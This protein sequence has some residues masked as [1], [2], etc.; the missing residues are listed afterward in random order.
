MVWLNFSK[1]EKIAT[2]TTFSAPFVRSLLPPNTNIL[3][4]GISFRVKTTDI[5][6]QYD[7]NSRTCSD[8]LSMLEGVDFT[9][10]YS[11]V[12]DIR[13]L[14]III[15]IISTEGLIFSCTSTMSFRIPFYP[16]LLKE[17]IQVYPIYTWIG[18]KGNDQN[19]HQPQ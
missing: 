6:N 9:V 15:A 1:Y 11:P 3:I 12:D 14:C 4:L 18:I 13:S 8:V 5:D 17:Y 7:I 10:S 2:S 16:T 19:I